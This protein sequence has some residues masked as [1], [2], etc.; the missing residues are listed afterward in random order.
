[1]NNKKSIVITAI[2]TVF[3]TSAFYMT[4]VGE[5]IYLIIKTVSGDMSFSAKMDRM[6]QLVDKYYI[7]EYD[8]KKMEDAALSAYAAEINDPY[9]MYI[10]KDNYTAMLESM[11]GDYVGIGVE[12]YINDDFIT[13]M[14][15][16]ENSPAKKAGILKGDKIIAVEGEKADS[17]NYQ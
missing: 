8:S 12:V 7:N 11:G 16:F 4:P 5:N 17:S 15:V 13:I 3:L 9:T 10:N 2:V 1:M 14:S 6:S